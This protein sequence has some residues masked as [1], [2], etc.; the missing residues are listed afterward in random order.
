V[1]I[2]T[3]RDRILNDGLQYK[4]RRHLRFSPFCF[5]PLLRRVNPIRAPFLFSSVPI[6]GQCLVY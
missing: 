3:L 5:L 1:V 4:T 6:I 2:A